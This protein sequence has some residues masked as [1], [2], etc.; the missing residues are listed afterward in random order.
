MFHEIEVRHQIYTENSGSG[1]CSPSCWYVIAT[2]YLVKIYKSVL[3]HA[4]RAAKRLMKFKDARFVQGFRFPSHLEHLKNHLP[5]PADTQADSSA[6]QGERCSQEE[7]GMQGSDEKDR[8]AEQNRLKQEEGSSAE[9][10]WEE[11]EEDKDEDK[12][13]A[14]KDDPFPAAL[15]DLTS[16]DL[17]SEDLTSECESLWW[18]HSL[19]YPILSQK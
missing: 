17:T 15:P 3:E 7:S 5:A 2:L 19:I 13:V 12:N 16:E 10:D 1:D 8:S 6:E 4:E 9:Q 11:E 14:E 18:S